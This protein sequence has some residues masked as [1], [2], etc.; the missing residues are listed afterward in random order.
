MDVK[1]GRGSGKCQ[2]MLKEE[3]GSSWEL[4]MDVKRGEGDPGSCQWTLRG[5]GVQGVASGR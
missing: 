4:P 3:R 2:W 1:W 5:K